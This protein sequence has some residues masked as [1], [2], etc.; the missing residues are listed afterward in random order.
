LYGCG[1]AKGTFLNP[2]EREAQ[3]AG[4]KEN[5]KEGQ[6]RNPTAELDCLKRGSVGKWSAGVSDT[7]ADKSVHRNVPIL[8]IPKGKGGTH[9]ERRKMG[10]SASWY[11]S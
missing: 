10:R 5:G 7:R 11:R 6:G 9:E 3:L 8:I 2:R 1:V 4:E